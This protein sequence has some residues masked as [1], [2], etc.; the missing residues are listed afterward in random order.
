MVKTVSHQLLLLK[1]EKM[2]MVIQVFGLSF[3]TPMVELLVVPLFVTVK[4]EKLQVFL[5]NL[6]KTK[7]DKQVIG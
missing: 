6:E 5:R 3:V 1:L 4:M 2:K 7:M